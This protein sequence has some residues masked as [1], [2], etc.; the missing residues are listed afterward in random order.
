MAYNVYFCCDTCGV[1][2]NWVNHT[3]SLS[4]A[5]AIARSYG[6]SVGKRGWFCPECRKKR[7]MRE[8]GRSANN[9]K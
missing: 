2:H 7:R 1:T 5:I 9:G 4:T 6:W 8:N 3:V